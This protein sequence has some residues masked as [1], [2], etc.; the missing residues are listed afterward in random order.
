MYDYQEGETRTPQPISA[1]RRVKQERK[2][3]A[4]T[5]I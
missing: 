3:E 4:Q 2:K 1:M 5:H